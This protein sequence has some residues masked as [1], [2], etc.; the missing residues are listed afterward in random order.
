MSGVDAAEAWK[1]FGTLYRLMYPSY[2]LSEYDGSRAKAW[3]AS[4]RR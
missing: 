2:D 3:A 4:A 1:K